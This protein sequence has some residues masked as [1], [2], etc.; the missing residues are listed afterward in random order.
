[1]GNV[2]KDDLWD[3]LCR[4]ENDDSFR[5]LVTKWLG[6]EYGMADYMVNEFILTLQEICM[7]D[8]FEG[9]DGGEIDSDFEEPLMTL[10]SVYKNQCG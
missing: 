9:F 5:R 2:L 1:M 7:D 3:L 4:L 6:S 10:L 8:N